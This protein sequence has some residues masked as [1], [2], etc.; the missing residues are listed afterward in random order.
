MKFIKLQDGTM[1]NVSAVKLYKPDQ[2]ESVEEIFE[3]AGG[4]GISKKTGQRV[5]R[6]TVLKIETQDGESHTL[7]GSVADAALKVLQGC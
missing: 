5:T 2:C 7:R 4:S 3:P 6:E 1:L